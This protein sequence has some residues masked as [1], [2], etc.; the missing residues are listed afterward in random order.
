V[1]VDPVL[2]ATALNSSAEWI[3][4]VIAILAAGVY[5]IGM[6]LQQ[7]GN[8]AVMTRAAE[9]GRPQDAGARKVLANGLWWVGMATM[10][11][12]FVLHAVALGIGSLA[13]VQPLQV[14]EIIFMIPASAWVAHVAITRRD[15]LSAAAVAVG[16]AM[17]LVAT[18]PGQG[19][20]VA[21]GPSGWLVTFAAVAA[22][23]V[24]LYLVAQRETRYRAALLGAMTGVVFGLQAAVLKQATGQLGDIELGDA[25]T[26]WAIPTVMA[27]NLVALVGQNL[28]MRAGRLSA[29]LS[30]ITVLTPAVS[31][32]LGIA[33][34]GETLNS[35]PLNIVAAT[36]GVAV[37]VAGVV[38]LAASPALLAAEG[39]ELEAEEGVAPAAAPQWSADPTSPGL[40]ELALESSYLE[41][42]SLDDTP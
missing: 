32:L 42:T 8:L 17:F 38:Q 7:K 18:Q 14:T 9:A 33:L 31:T 40:V 29:A 21:S 1:R 16:L 10:I 4:A 22:A 3:A 23:A 12:G 41:S 20:E 6:A 2:A 39:D 27:V 25:S 24:A 19:D 28:A 36:I 30:T 26:W 13:V 37:T 11:F 15:W 34:F 35:A 5:V